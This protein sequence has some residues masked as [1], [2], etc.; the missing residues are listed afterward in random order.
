[1]DNSSLLAEA[2][3]YICSIASGSNG[4]AYWIQ[5]QDTA[6][7]IDCGIGY[8][9]MVKRAKLVGIDLKLLSA[10]FISHEHSDH[11]RGLKVLANHHKH[12]QCYMTAGTAKGV[13]EYY[14]PIDGSRV[15]LMPSEGVVT[16]GPIEVTSF[17]KP[18]DVKEPV[19][20]T[21]R[22]ADGITI[23]VYTDIGRPTERLVQEL[24]QCDAAFLE[25]NYD[26]EMLRT[27]SYPL[28]LKNRITGGEGHISNKEAFDLVSN[29]S[30]PYKMQALVLSHLSGENNKPQ[31]VRELFE[32]FEEYM[33]VYT[34]SRNGAGVVIKLEKS[35]LK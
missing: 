32:P 27:G 8:R 24:E 31:V 34:A 15:H 21:V 9:E 12:M 22:T 10:I 16:V 35:D 18:H 3:T 29:L 20:F 1:M 7:L 25:S 23:G 19:S 26:I 13:R 17:V 11:V 33:R 30:K 14:M 5:C 4:N 2:S 6:I 28:Y